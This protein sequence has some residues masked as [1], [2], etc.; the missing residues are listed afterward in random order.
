M[1]GNLVY[2]QDPEGSERDGEVRF[3]ALYATGERWTFG[4]DSR[5]RFAIGGQKSATAVAEPKLDLLAG[6]V[7]TATVGPIALYAEAGPSVLKVT[8]NTSV[9]AA[10]VGGLGSVF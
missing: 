4:F 5:V 7:A 10:A 9:G 1:L 3:A 8:G 6:P 2:G